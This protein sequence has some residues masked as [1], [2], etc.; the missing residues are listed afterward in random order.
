MSRKGEDCV[1]HHV[2]TLLDG[3][4]LTNSRYIGRVRLEIRVVRPQMP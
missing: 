2:F 3:S 4:R 1:L